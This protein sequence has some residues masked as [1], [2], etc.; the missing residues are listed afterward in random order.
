MKGVRG[1]WRGDYVCV[2]AGV[3]GGSCA[4]TTPG[5]PA[6]APR[7]AEAGLITPDE[8]AAKRRAV[9]DEL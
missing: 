8:Y 2:L 4:T 6:A 3:L 9:L 7:Q 1:R 5:A